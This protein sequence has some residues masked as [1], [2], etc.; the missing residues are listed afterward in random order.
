MHTCFSTS[1][2]RQK[3]LKR[4]YTSPHKVINGTADP[5]FEI[6]IIGSPRRVSV[7]NVKPAHFLRNDV[8]VPS[9]SNEKTVPVT[10]LKTVTNVNKKNATNVVPTSL[11]NASN[12]V[13]P[14]NTYS[15]K[16]KCPLLPINFLSYNSGKSQE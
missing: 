15:R 8:S 5:I 4:P 9:C 13:P 16:K 7:E 12:V 10:N 3:S 1:T 6:D 14:L 2:H 11:D